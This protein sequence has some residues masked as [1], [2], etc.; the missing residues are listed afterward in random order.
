MLGELHSLLF[1]CTRPLVL[2]L[3]DCH[4]LNPLG[5]MQPTVNWREGADRQAAPGSMKG[6][7]VLY[8]VPPFAIGSSA[9][10]LYTLILGPAPLISVDAEAR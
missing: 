9:G 10:H 3:D 5:R 6:D 1:V 2:V 7:T 8:P 4:R